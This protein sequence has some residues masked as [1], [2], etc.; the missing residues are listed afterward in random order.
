MYEL[1]FVEFDDMMDDHKAQREIERE[2]REEEAAEWLTKKG[3]KNKGKAPT[4]T[5]NPPKGEK[6]KNAPT[7]PDGV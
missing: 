6:C 5:N 7:S 2:M 3:G 1:Q 4:I